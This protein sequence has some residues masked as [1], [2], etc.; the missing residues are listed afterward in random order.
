[1]FTVGNI[2]DQI[3]SEECVY[4]RENLRP[5]CEWK[6]VEIMSDDRRLSDVSRGKQC[7]YMS[8]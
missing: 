6:E 4:S 8:Y 2:C 5:N 3:A 1:M 7:A